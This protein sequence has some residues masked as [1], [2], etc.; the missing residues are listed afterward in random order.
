MIIVGKKRALA[1]CRRHADACKRLKS[2]ILEVE[3]AHWSRPQD[4]KN[5]YPHAS[6][7]AQN[8]VIFNIRG[9]NYRLD[10]A[11]DYETETV[12]IMRIGTHEEYEMWEF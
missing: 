7:L 10:A 5:R 8:R 4:I 12:V 1:F 9:P 3:E 11:V 2:W 6:F